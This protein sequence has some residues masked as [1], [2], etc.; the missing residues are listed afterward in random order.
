M[1]FI[2]VDV[3]KD[4][5]VINCGMQGEKDAEGVHFDISSWVEEHGTGKA[6]IYIRRNKD[7]TAYF[8]EME[9]TNN[10]A[11]WLFSAADTA[12]AGSGRAQA[13]YITTGEDVV[14]KSPWYRTNIG[15]S[16]GEAS[17][18]EPDPYQEMATE[19][20]DRIEA[21]EEEITEEALAEISS[22]K[23]E[24]LDAI[25]DT[26]FN[27]APAFA[28]TAPYS[29]GDI[30]LYNG[31]LYEFSADH[32]AGAW[33]G[34]DATQTTVAGELTGLKEDIDALGLSVVD[35]AINVTYTV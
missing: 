7:T 21:A 23:G 34:T 33:I 24:A 15:Q 4:I 1:A 29:A 11:E 17:E 28:T 2:D 30:V 5:S 13:V 6:Y 32:A 26:M 22:A 10:V 14:K 9:V 3:T 16:E 25:Q 27:L 20:I 12:R 19:V 18:D 8:R 35:G 31:A